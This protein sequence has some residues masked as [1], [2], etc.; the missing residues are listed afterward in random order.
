VLYY[1][2]VGPCR[3]EVGVEGRGWAVLAEVLPSK[4]EQPR[5]LKIVADVL[6]LAFCWHMANHALFA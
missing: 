1:A 5:Q 3:R 4:G 2:D 6:W